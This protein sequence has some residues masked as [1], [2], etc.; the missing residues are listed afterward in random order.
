[1]DVD[2]RPR[3]GGKP[4]STTTFHGYDPAQNLCGSI[5]RVPPS[6][7]SSRPEIALFVIVD[8]DVVVDGDG[9]VNEFSRKAVTRRRRRQGQ[10]PRYDHVNVDDHVETGISGR[11]LAKLAA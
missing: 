1:V 11:E 5:K 4:S 6:V 2:G 10:R 7:A 9:D 3:P 8:V